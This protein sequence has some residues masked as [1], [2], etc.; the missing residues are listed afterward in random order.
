MKHKPTQRQIYNAKLLMICESLDKQG[1][2]CGEDLLSEVVHMGSG[3]N[4]REIYRKL[5][6]LTN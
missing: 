2:G 4:L 3:L 6:G 1:K 5:G